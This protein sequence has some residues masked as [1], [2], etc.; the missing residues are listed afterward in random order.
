MNLLL[1]PVDPLGDFIQLFIQFL[2][3]L[4]LILGPFWPILRLVIVWVILLV[5]GSLVTRFVRRRAKKLGVPPNAVN[6][7]VMALRLIFVWLGVVAFATILPPEILV[8]VGDITVIVG[9]AVGIALSLAVRNFVAG[10]Y[11][12]VTNPFSVGDYVRIGSNEGIV[13]E[14]GLNYTRIRQLDGT[15]ALIPND[16][17]MSSS[18]TNFRFE[19]KIR[20]EAKEGQEA[21]QDESIPKR[22]W[23]ALSRAADTSKLIQYAFELGFPIAPGLRHYEEKLPPIMKRWTSK[24][25]FKPDF[26]LSSTSSLAFTYTFTIFVEDPKLLLDYRFDFIEEVTRA[27]Y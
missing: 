3:D 12:M 8:I 2:I 6:G 15:I 10:L 7:I 17:V 13:I 26:V 4:Q 16:K 1:Q 25:G 5:V 18:V 11:V 24:F 22:I 23:N 19:Q 14:I 20:L 27:V 21:E 9:L